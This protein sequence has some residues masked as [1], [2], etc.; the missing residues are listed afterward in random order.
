MA[1]VFEKVDDNTLKIKYEKAENHNY[2]MM[3]RRK[4]KLEAELAY[5]NKLIVEAVKL[6]IV[7]KEQLAGVVSVSENK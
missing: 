6:G 3:L 4:S 5:I 1:D 2:D 7:S